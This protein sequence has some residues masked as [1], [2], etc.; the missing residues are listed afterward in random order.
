MTNMHECRA[1]ERKMW[2]MFTLQERRLWQCIY[3]LDM[4]KFGGLGRKK[5]C[6]LERHCTSLIPTANGH[7]PDAVGKQDW[8][9]WQPVCSVS[10]VGCRT[11][12]MKKGVVTL[13]TVCLGGATERAV[14]IGPAWGGVISMGGAG[15][16]ITALSVAPPRHTVKR[17]TTPFFIASVRQPTELTEHT[18][19]HHDQSCCNS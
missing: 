13:L 2:G 14:M 5:K 11:L 19:C 6:C 3:C 1:Q 10:S 9:W 17:V 7:T 18:G 12:A 4:K 16:I 15:P 8:S